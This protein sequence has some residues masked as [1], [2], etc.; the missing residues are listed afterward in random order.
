LPVEYV[1]PATKVIEPELVIAVTPEFQL[2][3]NPVKLRL[4]TV[5][6]PEKAIVSEPA[7]TLMLKELATVVGEVDTVLV[8]A[9]PEKFNSTNGV[10]VTVAEVAP[11]KTVA[12]L[13][14][15]VILFVPNAKVPVNVD[16]DNVLQTAPVAIVIVF[17]PLRESNLTSSADVG[18]ACPP[19]PP[20]VKAHLEPAVPSHVSVPPTQNLLAITQ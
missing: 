10:P 4:F 6:V 11:L 2:P 1:I 12:L 16:N 14:D 20:E 3:V 17:A 7:V 9:P 5:G 15:I 18:T 19:A 13:P 8:P